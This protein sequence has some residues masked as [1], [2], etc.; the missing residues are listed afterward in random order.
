MR[1]DVEKSIWKHAVR[2]ALKHDAEADVNAVLGGVMSEHRD[3][4]PK[5]IMGDIQELLSEVNKLS[6]E[7][8]KHKAEE[9]DISF[10]SEEEDGVLPDLPGEG[11]GSVITRAAPNPNGPFHLG[12]ARAYILSYLYAERNGGNFILRYDDTN[13]SSPEK[14]PKKKFYSWIEEDL[15]WLGC[16]PDIVIKSSD[17]LDVYYEFAYELIESGD[18]YVC[19]CSPEKWKDLRDQSKGCP[20][21]EMDPDKHVKRWHKMQDGEYEQGEAVVRIKTDIKHKNPARRDWPALR[22]LKD[23]EHPYVSKD[24]NVWPLYNFASAIDDHELNVTHIFRA[25]EHST[26]T[27]NQKDLYNLFGWKY[28]ETIHHGFLSLKGAVLSTSTIRNGIQTGKYEGWD[29]PR[30]GTIKA[31]KRRGFQ[32]K[33]IEKLIRKYS[34]KGSNAEVSMEE[35]TSINRKIVDPIANRYFFVEE[36]FCIEVKGSKK[37]GTIELPMHPEKDDKRTVEVGDRFL[38]EKKDIEDNRGK[39]IRL[40]GLYNIKVPENGN[41]CEFAGDSIVQDMP[42]V[43]WLPNS[44]NEEITEAEIMM[45]DAGKKRGKVEKNVLDEQIDNVLQF[46]R[47]GFVRLDEKSERG[48][49]F[50]FAHK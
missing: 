16:K 4:S 44:E 27:E 28:P 19:E 10:E 34:I 39:T 7:E 30:L 1:D 26:N 49:K 47:F 11:E 37:K 31:L 40:K 9:F 43:H 41:N 50:W 13:P 6:E 23:H 17:R 29:D 45:P 8:L 14:S 24:Y 12:N 33:A 22:I 2:N 32:A 38:V 42:K 46:E 36:P 18:A 3:L 48:P 15:K 5:E 20:C 35:F 21:R 25:K